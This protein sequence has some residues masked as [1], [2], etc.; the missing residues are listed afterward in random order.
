MKNGEWGMGNGEWRISDERR[1]ESVMSFEC[2]VVSVGARHA[3][4]SASSVNR[5][6]CQPLIYTDEH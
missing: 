1:G 5:K 2:W 6:T 4:L 3:L